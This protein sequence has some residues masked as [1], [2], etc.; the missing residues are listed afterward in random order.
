MTTINDAYINALLADAC[1]V[2]DLIPEMTGVALAGKIGGSMTPALATYIADNFTVIQQVGGL[3]S[4]F[5]ATVWRGNAGTAYS[6]QVYVSMRGTQEG[7]D[8]FAADSD[9]ASSGLAHRQLVDMVNWWLRETT[10]AHFDDGMSRFATQITLTAD[11]DFA[12]GALVLATGRLANIGTI[13]S[14]NGHS[15]GGYLAS[16]FV[17]LFGIQLFGTQLPVTAI[18]TF[19]S[20]GFSKQAAANIENGFSQIARLIGPALGLAGFSDAQNNYFGVNGANVTANTVGFQQYGT[21]IPLFQEDSGGASN[22]SMYK[23]TDLLTLGNALARLDPTLDFG[24]LST[25]VSGGSNQMAA[26]YEGVFDAARRLVGGPNVTATPTTDASGSNAGQPQARIEFQAS[27]KALTDS[28]AFISLT[29]KVTIASIGNNLATQAKARLDFEEIAALRTLSPFL[30]SAVGADG[31]AA[32]AALWQSTAWG[33]DYQ[34][35]LADKASLEAGGEASAFTNSWIDDRSMLL[36]DVL[37]VNTA[38]ITSGIV[39]DIALPTDRAVE[40]RYFEPGSQQSKTLTAHNPTFNI[41]GNTSAR[42]LISFGSDIG[43]PL[44]GI[45]SRF[46]DHLY[47]GG[48]NDTI[49]GLAGNDYLEG[50]AGDDTLDGGKGID[51]LKGG[52]GNDTYILRAE[53]SDATDTI[54]D[55]DGRGCIKVYGSDGSETVLSM[56]GGKKLADSTNIWQSND[57]RFTFTLLSG[58]DGSGTLRISGAGVKALVKNFTSGNL[59]IDLPD[60]ATVPL[61]P[62]TSLTI[63]GDLEPASPLQQDSLGNVITTD[64]AAPGR[65][66]TLYDSGGDDKIEAGGGADLIIAHRG[67]NDWIRS[68]DGDDMVFDYGGDD[69][70]E[71]GAGRDIAY[72]GDGKDSIFGNTAGGFDAEL[73]KTEVAS[74]SERNILDG[75]SGDDVVV[76]DAGGDALFG[77]GGKD[78]LVGSAGDDIMFGDRATYKT[79]YGIPDVQLVPTYDAQ[80]N[81]VARTVVFTALEHDL[82]TDQDADLLLGGAGADV[83]LGDGGDDYLDGGSGNDYLAGGAGS[84]AL[85]GAEGNDELD[86]DGSPSADESLEYVASQLHGDDLL[87]GGVGNDRLNGGGGGDELFGGDGDDRLYGD[88]SALEASLQGNDYLDG[89]AGADTLVG[90]GGDDQLVGGEGD[91]VL[92]GDATDLA[93]SAHG[94]DYL[95]GGDGADWMFGDGGNDELFG[96]AGDDILWG[97]NDTLAAQYHGDDYLDGEDGNDELVGG[98]GNDQLFGGAGDDRLFGDDDIVAE[99]SHGTDYLDGEEGND[100][101]RGYGGND[102]LIGGAGDD[103]LIGDSGNDTLEGGAGWDQLVG[104]GGDDTYVFNAGDTDGLA[105]AEV[106]D[107]VEGVNHIELKRMG[108]AAIDLLPTTDAQVNLIQSG[109]DAIFISELLGSSIASVEVSG[110]TYSN[111]EFFGKTYVDQIIESTSAAFSRLQGGRLSDVLTATGGNSIVA[112]GAGDDTLNGDGGNNIYRYGLDDGIDTITDISPASGSSGPQANTLSFGSGI[113]AQDLVLSRAGDALVIGFGAGTTGQVRL[114]GFDANDVLHKAGIDRFEFA[115]GTVLT[116][117]ELVTRGIYGLD[118]TEPATLTGTSAADHLIGDGRDNTLYGLGGDDVL[119]GGDGNDLLASG[120]GNDTLLGQAGDD[121]LQGGAGNDVLDGGDGNDILVAGSGATTMIGGAG[122]T[123][124]IV[125]ADSHATINDMKSS[126]WLRF[127]SGATFADVTVSSTTDSDGTSV[128]TLTTTA[129]GSVTIHAGASGLLGQV[130][131]ADGSAIA[132]GQLLGT[133]ANDGSGR[134]TTTIFSSDGAKVGESWTADDGSHGGVTFNSDGSTNGTTYAA[135]GS[136]SA[137][138]DDGHG[139]VTTH[140]FSWSGTETGSSVSK[141]HGNQNIITDFLDA[142]GAKVNETF[143]HSNGSTGTDLISPVDFVGVLNVLEAQK[144]AYAGD[145]SWTTPDGA[146][147]DS[148]GP[149]GN[150]TSY[151]SDWSLPPDPGMSWG[152]YGRIKVSAAGDDLDVQ[153]WLADSSYLLNQSWAGGAYSEFSDRQAQVSFYTTLR[154]GQKTTYTGHWNGSTWESAEQTVPSVSTPITMTV[155]GNNGTYSTLFE[156]GYGNAV[157][158]SY[159]AQG[160]RTFDIWF[161]NDGTYGTD[162]FGAGN[163]SEGF[164]VDADGSVH[165]YRSDGHGSS[166]TINYPGAFATLTETQNSAPSEIILAPAPTDLHSVPGTGLSKPELLTQSDDGNGGRYV[167]QWNFDGSVNVSHIDSH[168][169]LLNDRLVMTDPGYAATAYVDGKKLTWNYDLAGTPTSFEIHD[170]QG[171]VVTRYLNRDGAATSRELASASNA[172]LTTTQLFDTAGDAVG[173]TSTNTAT[174]GG[175]TTTTVMRFDASGQVSGTTTVLSDGA[176]NTLT[177]DYDA[178]L[179][180]LSTRTTVVMQDGDI[181]STTYDAQGAATFALVTSTTAEG[182][183]RTNTYDGNGMLT[184]SVVARSDG[185]G[186]VVT[187]NHDA[188]GALTSYVTMRSDGQNGTEITTYDSQARK[189]RA[190]VL[191]AT[192][193]HESTEFRLDGSRLTT[194]VAVDGTYTVT[195]RDAVGGAVTAQYDELGMKLSDVWSRSDGSSGTDLFYPDGTASG[196]ASYADG[197]SSS[198]TIDANGRATTT[199]FGADGTVVTGTT[200]TT[201]VAGETRTVQYDADGE[202]LADT[203]VKADG[204]SGSDTWNADG[205]ISSTVVDPDGSTRSFTTGGANHAPLLANPLADQTALQDAAWSFTI[206]IDTFA[207]VD[208]GDTLVFAAALAESTPLPPWLSFDA[209]TRSFSGTPANSD[210]GTV[211]LQVGA[212]D[213]SGASASATFTLTVQNVN[214]APEVNVV[215]ADLLAAETRPLDVQLPVG[216]FVDADSGDQLTWSMTLADGQ[217]LPAWLAF[218]ASTRTL[219]GT[220]G[221][222]DG[223]TLSLYVTATDGSGVSSSQTFALNIRSAPTVAQALVDQAAVEDA[224]WIFKV[225]NATFA[226]RDAADTL[227][228]TA[229]RAD[230]APL[231]SWLSFDAATLTFQGTPANDDVGILAVKLAASDPIGLTASDVF[232]LTVTNTNDAPTVTRAI[233]SQATAEDQAWTLTIPADTFADVDAGDTLAYGAKLADGAPLPLWLRFD[234]ATRTF[235]GTPLNADVGSLSVEILATDAA[236]ARA[237]CAFTLTVVNVN[238][239]P[240][241]VGTLMDWS[242]S[243]GD[244]V[245]YVVPSAAFEDID[246]GDALRYSAGLGN[247]DALPAWLAFDAETRT[248][249]GTPTANDAGDFVLKV[250]ATDADGLAASQ[251]IRLQVGQLIL[252]TSGADTLTGGAGNDYLDGLAGADRMVGGKGDDRYVVDNSRDTVAELPGEGVDTVYSSVTYTLPANVENLVLA[253]VSGPPTPTLPPTAMVPGIDGTGNDLDNL[254][255]GNSQ[256]NVLMGGRGADTLDG[257]KGNDRLLGGAGNDNYLFRRGSAHDTI[258]EDDT[259]AGNTDVALFGGDI[260]FDQLWFA[261]KGNDLEITVLGTN[262]VLAIDSWYKGS[263]HHVEQFRTSDGRTLLDSRVQN[264]VDAMAGFSPPA[265]GQTVLPSSYQNALAGVIAASWQ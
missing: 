231:P 127:N 245:T 179:Q 69:L 151:E 130:K 140:F 6:G 118:A 170:G 181:V 152:S 227:T 103:T 150:Y 172:G 91:D 14:V 128:V 113:S 202:S 217:P 248:F 215:A 190:D 218:D 70:I 93:G 45:E 209:A 22:H 122:I 232:E 132:L 101:L 184:G 39:T 154:N 247:G 112:G 61:N 264:L 205:S 11:N 233:A 141:T 169:E 149:S 153:M 13:Q 262:D 210:V 142:S 15:L 87:D 204:S 4:S 44:N 89:G 188:D 252:G 171:G 236:G 173:S 254:L 121:R 249:G 20:A 98:A 194:T 260:A 196:T 176:G 199:H 65:N 88:N 185:E 71:L 81:V 203:W 72:G 48:G 134:V 26:S 198:S 146:D 23:L 124:Y 64:V 108:L 27:L 52:Q 114:T 111:W 94:N 83:M 243:A 123:T 21:R 158:T 197:T 257:G 241:P 67:G 115:D 265:A 104:G 225:P 37:Q 166:A 162:R 51:T 50:N 148:Y 221:M 259:T 102:T 263:E 168:G 79:L 74:A 161:H 235:S 255:I 97:D 250:T 66:D 116:H 42:Q 234:A 36:K 178:G 129:G 68:G 139:T 126:D 159:S 106:V 117:A 164:S 17:R 109:Q 96:D 41:A 78:V 138:L 56:T 183:I 12:A 99:A 242:V 239:A 62:T 34:A 143:R 16:A 32:L 8:Y 207:D 223:G 2:D 213:A 29:G 18:S 238:D 110:I 7:T 219:S 195:A 261:Q 182:V 10:P 253:E 57:Q 258:E 55:S 30:V 119:E 214:D 60:A 191:R 3:S 175:I 35:W 200:V 107:D 216:L 105:L 85:L 46:G 163:S 229:T 240:V 53:T 144:N 1:Y 226:D 63:S 90:Q 208:A 137:Y 237:I 224:E 157:M 256:N 24:K 73:G 228:Y 156:D 31:A 212:T 59:G 193:I 136:S 165:T 131:F 222:G 147:G 192:G 211:S 5:D 145:I 38:D 58:P 25:L 75:G 167:Y 251:T 54:I 33:T 180:L 84:D 135:D 186:G 77:A 206:P 160:V 100:S 9:L 201:R 95:D 82:P 230:G 177:S 246:V 174:D 40:L 155:Q 76:A 92:S 244:A 120:E 187:T 43:E 125:N 47:G 189:I 133:T 86:G 49:D 80:G 220:P 28:S 19:N